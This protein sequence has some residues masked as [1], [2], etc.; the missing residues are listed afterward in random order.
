M[1]EHRNTAVTYHNLVLFMKEKKII[2][3]QKI[4]IINQLIWRKIFGKDNACNLW[5]KR[6][7]L[8]ILK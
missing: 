4:I 1:Q 2:K 7:G 5:L 6:L 8:L 3:K